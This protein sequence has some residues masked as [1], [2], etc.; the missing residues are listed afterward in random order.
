M[1]NG[2]VR[3]PE[4]APVAAAHPARR[5]MPPALR[6]V[7]EFWKAYA[8]KIAFYQTA[9]ILTAIY[10]VVVGPIWLFGRITGHRFLPGHARTAASFWY[11][12]QM[13]RFA[14]LDELKKQ[15]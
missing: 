13:G 6:L 14:G 4:L 2:R 10:G 12:A 3:S 8:E 9:V 7:W 11:P 1:Q 5:G 15:G